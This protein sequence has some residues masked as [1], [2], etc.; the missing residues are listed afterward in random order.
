MGNERALEIYRT[1][2]LHVITQLAELSSSMKIAC[3]PDEAAAEITHWLGS[4]LRTEGQGDGNMG[5][6]L[7]RCIARELAGGAERVMVLG[8]DCPE[9]SAQLVADAFLLLDSHDAVFGPA[10]DGG[11]YLV[12]VHRRARAAAGALFREIPWSTPKV[13]A[14]TLAAAK[15]NGLTVALTKSLADIDT[16]QDWRQWQ[17]RVALAGTP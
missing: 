14:I 16:E 4:H 9:I 15:R 12:G 11:Y 3:A 5:A 13:L 8:T 7:E 10:F 2:G 17:H 1:L 6:R